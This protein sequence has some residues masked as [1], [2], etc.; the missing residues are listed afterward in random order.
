MQRL[1]SQGEKEIE[2]G[3]KMKMGFRNQN[4]LTRTQSKKNQQN[5]K[6]RARSGIHQP[7]P[8]LTAAL[9]EILTRHQQTSFY[10][11]NKNS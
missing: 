7:H 4:V 8:T 10:K 11:S 1:K 9:Y 6:P 5:S 3:E 2:E